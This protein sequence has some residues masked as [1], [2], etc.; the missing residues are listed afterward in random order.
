MESGTWLVG[1]FK[2][3]AALFIWAGAVAGAFGADA[4][5]KPG[6]DIKV[7]G[8]V[9]DA[10]TKK[11]IPTFTITEGRRSPYG[12]EMN[13]LSTRATDGVEGKFEI[14]FT[15]QSQALAVMIEANGYVPKSSGLI[16]TNGTNITIALR[17]GSGPGGLVLN[18]D[19]KPAS[20]VI[21]YLNDMKNGV[22]VSENNLSV[23]DNIYRGTTSTRTDATGHFSFRP[24]IDAFSVIVI[25]DA[26]YAE[27]RMEDLENHSEVHL[28]P[29][30]RVEGKLMIG[31]RPGTDESVRLGLAHVPY[32]SQPRSFPALSL[33]LTTRTD[34]EGKFVFERVPPIAIEVYHEPKVRDSRTG[35][36]P[37]AQTTKFDLKPGDTK[38][39]VLG[40]KGCPVV[41]RLV[42]N[43]Y[44]GTID[45]RADVHS[46]ESILPQPAELPDMMAMS[47]EFSAK[48]RALENDD[49]KKAVQEE[50]MKQRDTAMEKQKA[51]FKTEAGRQYHFSKTRNALNFSKDGSFRIDDVPGGKYTLK[52]ELREGSGDS[53][54]RFSAPLIA[55]LTKEIEVPD[56][57]GGR[58]DEPFDLGT[59]SVE[60][61]A[62]M[63]KGKAAPDFEVKT[64]D[65]KPLRLADFKGKYLL[66][67]FWAVW[68]GPCVAETPHLKSAW[69][70]FKD[71]PRFAMIGLSLDPEAAA[72]RNYT[73]KNEIGWTQGFLGEWSKSDVPDRFGVQ[74]I[75]AIFLI[76]PDGKIIAKDLR[77][78]AIKAAIASA[79]KK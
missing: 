61:K 23:R 66:L 65:D 39:L 51:F 56:S 55:N 45:Y 54:S 4:A 41:G 13:W 2:R 60:A 21:V 44:E 59:L 53:P 15:K 10:E 9:I 52:I 62:I 16:G 70:T 26:G 7:T 19:G 25:E 47:K 34:N 17:K 14:Y 42:V 37:Q 20:N 3:S 1:W 79:L 6:G 50:F 72:P 40:G 49:V 31:T 43:G 18:P 38:H 24:Q 75:P 74:G 64:I 46:L 76:G 57:R 32:E 28:Q 27:V 77:G 63:K 35:T 22:Y 69:E 30:G 11:P 78:D 12:E 58:T 33:F 29:Y 71:D 68:C 8:T 73:K 48:F 5:K 36:V 67:D